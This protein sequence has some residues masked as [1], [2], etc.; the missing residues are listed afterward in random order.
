MNRILR[1]LRKTTRKQEDNR[2]L[3]IRMDE[4]SANRLERLRGLFKG[5]DDGELIALALKSLERQTNRVVRRRVLKRIRALGRRGFNPQQI[6]HQLNDQGVPVP[7]QA[8]KWD[9][10]EVFRFSG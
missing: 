8:E 5:I 6:A 9:S 2:E 10:G 7:G 1:L 4:D 3:S